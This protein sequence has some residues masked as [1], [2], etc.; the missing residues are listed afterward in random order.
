MAAIAAVAAITPVATVS[1]V[2]TIASVARAAIASAAVA[3]AATAG[4]V[5]EQA[6][7]RL[8]AAQQ[9][10]ANQRHENRDSKQNSAVHPGILQINLLVP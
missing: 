8:I 9:G 1:A 2:A 6:G 10:H 3:A 5:E 7:I 4:A